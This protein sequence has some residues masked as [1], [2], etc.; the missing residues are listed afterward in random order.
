MQISSFY[1]ENSACMLTQY[2]SGHFLSSS[3]GLG[4]K[5]GSGRKKKK[6]GGGV[7]AGLEMSLLLHKAR[8][9]K[10]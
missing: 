7:V 9:V 6:S 8:E 5:L 4:T 10:A 2:V 1:L 3:K